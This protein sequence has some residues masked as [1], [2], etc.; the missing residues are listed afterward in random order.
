MIAV[1]PTVLDQL[2]LRR[3]EAVH[4]GF[5]YQHLYAI[6]CLLMAAK[7]GA[8]TVVVERDEDVEVVFQDRRLYVQV[9]TRSEGLGPNDVG[10]ALERF[11]AL[12][13]EHASGRRIGKPGFAIVANVDPKPPRATS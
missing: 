11:E 6:G 1:Q 8:T 12:R 5:L 7:T 13:E 9:K 3:I 10:G 2:Q 4:R